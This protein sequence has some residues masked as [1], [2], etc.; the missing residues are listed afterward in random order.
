MIFRLHFWLQELLQASLGF[1]WSFGFA[2]ICLDTLGGQVLHHDSISMIVSSF[3]TFT[4]N[5]VICC[6]QVTKS[7]STRHGSAIAPSARGPCN[8]WFSDR[9]RNFGLW[10]NEFKHCAYPSPRLLDVG[11][12]DGAWGELACESLRSGTLSSTKFSLNSCSHSGMSEHN[13]LPRSVPWFSFLFGSGFLVGLVNGSPRSF[14]WTREL[15]TDAGWESI[16]LKSSRARVPLS[17]DTIVVGNVRKN[18][19]INQEPRSER[20]SPYCTFPNDRTAGVFSRTFI[21]KNFSNSLT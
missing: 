20:N 17:L 10:W 18:S 15:D 14:R 7:F 3:T 2:R 12:K 8:F 9:S 1:L 6:F 4:E 5:F 13:G 19:L 11:S 16:P 21:V